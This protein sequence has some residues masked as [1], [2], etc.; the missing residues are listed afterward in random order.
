MNMYFDCEF[1]GLQQNTTLI[2]LACV[3]E[4]G[5]EFYLATHEFDHSQVNDW[6]RKNVLDNL[7][8]EV[9][10]VSREELA[11]RL[12]EWL[13]KFDHVEMWGDV[14][15][16]DWMLFCELF[17]A[18]DTAERLPRNVYYI[19]FDIATLMKIKG[20]D[21][22]ISREE[23]SGVKGAKHNALRDARVIKACYDN[24][25]RAPQ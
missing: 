13:S 10:F 24:L 22:D 19:P 11:K 12:A 18:E 3:A 23:F 14:L 20:I 21:P 7:L 15:P 25:T 17:D 16:Y 1:T 9:E 8:D 5:D 6:I 4:N 2:S